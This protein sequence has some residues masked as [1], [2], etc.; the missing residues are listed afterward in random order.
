MTGTGKTDTLLSL[1]EAAA[2]SGKLKK[3]VLSRPYEGSALREVGRLCLHRGTRVLAFETSFPDGKVHHSRLSLPLEKP[4][5]WE[6]LSSYAQINLITTD[7]N[8]EYRRAASGAE[9]LLAP[10]D[11]AGR[12]S[13][14]GISLP[15][16]ELNRK[17]QYILSGNEAFL[18]GLEISDANGRVHDK[19]QAKF[20][21]INRFLEHLREVE[22]ALPQEG[23]LRIFDLCCGKSYLSFAV[24]HYF[25]AIKGREVDMLCVDLKQ[26]VIDFCADEAKKLGFSGMRFLCDDVRRTPR[27]LPHLVLS[28][29][30]CDIATDLVLETA[31]ALG[32]KA[33][34]STP[35][36][37]RTL[38]KFLSAMPLS[39]VSRE[40]QLRV[41]L[42]EALTDGLRVLRLGAA[43]YRVTALELTDPENT[44][45]NTL[46]RAVH[47]KAPGA[48]ARR[49]EAQKEYEAALAYLLGEHTE[50]YL[51]AIH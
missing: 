2:D 13:S 12:L 10:R 43:G 17:K 19:K 29:H 11:L 41:K 40:P 42:C 27:E 30:A 25:T 32:A 39:F 50:D 1:I 6:R 37:H 46:L 21:Q 24:Y 35:C 16:S 49:C 38:G 45:K 33:I 44:P 34:L 18:K 36:C 51:A 20:R 23:V 14:L 5:L 4:Q 7:G 26:D 31:I 8:V 28:L 9:S 47:D 3:L 22:P 15:L 48:E